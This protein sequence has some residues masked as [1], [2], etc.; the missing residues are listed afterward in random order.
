MGE[1][2][3]LWLSV[4]PT[5]TLVGTQRKVPNF[6]RLETRF[7]LEK[8]SFLKT[9]LNRKA[10]HAGRLHSEIRGQYFKRIRGCLLDHGPAASASPRMRT[11]P[12]VSNFAKR[13][14][15]L[16]RVSASDKRDFGQFQLHSSLSRDSSQPTLKT[17][18]RNVRNA[19]C[20][21]W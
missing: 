6:G 12:N 11:R 21:R 17:T 15:K 7:S 18:F 19:T 16:R 8:L 2:S 13:S 1:Q 3:G 20:L 5:Q 10:S 9:T 4:G 14:L